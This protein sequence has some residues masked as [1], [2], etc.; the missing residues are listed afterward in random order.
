MSIALWCVLVAGLLPI[1]TTG[2][3]KWGAP[4]DNARPRESIEVLAGWR[5]RAYMAHLNG[6][7]AF[8]LFAAAVLVATIQGKSGVAIDL[9]AFSWI[10]TR[11]LYVAC[12]VGNWPTLRSLVWTVA[13]AL[14]IAIFTAPAWLSVN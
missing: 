14:A 13:L 8:P 7:E 9:L 12:Y 3:A 2:L 10:F 1:L 5:K 11:V 4:Y 6:W